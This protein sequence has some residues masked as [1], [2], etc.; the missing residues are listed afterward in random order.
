M[1]SKLEARIQSCEKRF[2]DR[3]STSPN[4]SDVESV[5]FLVNM[6]GDAL[7]TV[8]LEPSSDE[9]I[10]LNE[11]DLTLNVAAVHDEGG[12]LKFSVFGLEGDLGGSRRTDDTHVI[13]ISFQLQ[14]LIGST[15]ASD[16]TGTQ[17]T[18]APGPGNE[19]VEA[20]R[21]LKAMGVALLE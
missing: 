3:T 13:K 7:G 2:K 8:F 19:L 17:P 16:E 11:I 20:F 6:I 18:N 10:T 14:D 1:V 12:H 9:P 4:M 21:E 15:T 5:D